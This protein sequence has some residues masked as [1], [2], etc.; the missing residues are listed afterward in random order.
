MSSTCPQ[1]TFTWCSTSPLQHLLPSPSFSN[2]LPA[3]PDPSAW[4]NGSRNPCSPGV[5]P[6]ACSASPANADGAAQRALEA[7]CKPSTIYC[8]TVVLWWPVKFSWNR[9]RVQRLWRRKKELK[10]VSFHK[11]KKSCTQASFP[12]EATLK[13]TNLF[14]WCCCKAKFWKHV[15]DILNPD[16]Y[17]HQRTGKHN[18]ILFLLKEETDGT[19]YLIAEHFSLGKIQLWELW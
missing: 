12:W 8:R 10:W 16:K 18:A 17:W 2:S 11:H 6:P 4:P 7:A 13:I 9:F 5:L 14:L 1:H 3:P 15:W 19:V